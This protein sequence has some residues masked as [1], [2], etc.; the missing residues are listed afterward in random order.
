METNNMIKPLSC[1]EMENIYGGLNW[2]AAFDTV[3]GTATAYGGL[4]LGNPVAIIGGCLE[5]GYA[6]GQIFD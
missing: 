1:I 2:K 3:K 5:T 6:L 4:M